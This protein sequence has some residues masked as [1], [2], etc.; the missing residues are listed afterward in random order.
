MQG[1]D[2][3]DDLRPVTTPA[4]V[5][6]V[7][8][9]AARRL[10]SADE[11][12]PLTRLNDA[13]SVRAMAQTGGLIAVALAVGLWGLSNFAPWQ[14]LA[15]LWPASLQLADQP[16][17]ALLLL[18]VALVMVGVAQHGL[19]ILAHEAAHYRL[20][21]H[22]GL[23][24][25]VGRLIGMASGISMCTYRVIHRLHHN[26]L[27]GPQ[28]PDTA[29]HGG[30][31]R[32][33][34]YLWKKLAQD[35]AGWNAWKTYAYFFGAPAIN[36][37]DGQLRRSRAQRPQRHLAQPARRGSGR[38]LVGAGPAVAAAPAVPAGGRLACAGG[39]WAALAAAAAHRAATHPAAAGGL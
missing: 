25:T 39:L 2:F 37:D 27:Y 6:G 12:A 16:R 9:A 35:L 22:R 29:I 32:G 20:L 30:Y 10:L 26:H 31:P 13:R 3:R 4:P 5:A 19:F 8:N 14:G 1:E 21:S 7:G 34:A 33:V 24:D 11:L 17:T 18:L 36:A 38:P 28:D 23:N 15:A